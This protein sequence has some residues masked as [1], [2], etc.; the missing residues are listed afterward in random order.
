MQ[1][2]AQNGG[3]F[4]DTY[5]AAHTIHPESSALELPEGEHMP[6]TSFLII[7]SLRID[8]APILRGLLDFLVASRAT[9]RLREGSTAGMMIC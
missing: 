6:H 1:P 4:A 7:N 8:H 5:P 3:I 9:G 2:R